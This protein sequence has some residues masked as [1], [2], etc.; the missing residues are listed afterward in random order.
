M[1][2]RSSV[3]RSLAIAL[4]ALATALLPLTPAHAAYGPDQPVAI[5]LNATDPTNTGLARLEGTVAFDDGNTMFRYSLRL[6]WLH[7]YPAPQAR[8]V[9]NGTTVHSPV[10]T[11]TTYTPGCQQTYLYAAEV[12]HGA[13]V[14]NV[15]F[16]VTGGWFYPGNQYNMRTKSYTYDN[17]Y[18]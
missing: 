7:A 8:V 1:A 4:A 13:V 16:E 5:Q 10:Y 3:K 14:G 12:N 15:R 6:C 11:G 17:P 18:N 9:I 2:A